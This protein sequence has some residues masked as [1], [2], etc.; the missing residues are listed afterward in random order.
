MLWHN[1]I[2][3]SLFDHL[4]TAFKFESK[5]GSEAEN[6][7]SNVSLIDCL[8]EFKKPELLDEDNKWYCNK[9]KDHV[10]ATKTLEIYKVPPVMIVSLKRFRTGR[11]RFGGGQKI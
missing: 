5:E 7:D 10:Q 8:R 4:A 11:S 2:N 9:C 3:K 6:D 1:E